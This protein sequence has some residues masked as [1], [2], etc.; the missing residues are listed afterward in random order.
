MQNS[1]F[2]NGKIAVTLGVEDFRTH[3]ASEILNFQAE[4]F[5]FRKILIREILLYRMRNCE[6]FSFRIK[7]RGFKFKIARYQFT[8]AAIFENLNNI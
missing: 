6:I 7:T 8:N 2:P 5:N 3:T 1:T 4:S